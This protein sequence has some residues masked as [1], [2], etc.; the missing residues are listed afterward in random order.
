[1]STLKKYR[2]LLKPAFFIFNLLF[3]TWLVFQI[4]Q[5][6]PSDFGKYKYIFESPRKLPPAFARKQEIKKLCDQYKAGLLDSTQLEL[7]LSKIMELSN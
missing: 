2:F 1:M 3:S 5:I 4:E 6:S 7:K